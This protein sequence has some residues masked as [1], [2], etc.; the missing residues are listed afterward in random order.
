MTEKITLVAPDIS[1]GHCEATVKQVASAQ[2][3]VVS[4]NADSSTKLI[5][6]ELDPATAS[7]PA[8]EAALAEA[9]Y[10]ASK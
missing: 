1:C 7:L 6:I 2:P 4:V 10:P 5:V 3:G 8:I 9:G